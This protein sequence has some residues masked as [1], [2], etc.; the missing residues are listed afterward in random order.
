M[1]RCT[2]FFVGLALHLAF[3]ITLCRTHLGGEEFRDLITVQR[4]GWGF[5]LYSEIDWMYGP[6]Y[7]YLLQ[8]VFSL[9]GAAYEILNVRL[10]AVGFATIGYGAAYASCRGLMG[11]WW[12]VLAALLAGRAFLPPRATYNHHLAVAAFLAAAALL[13]SYAKRPRPGKVLAL[14][15]VAAV[16]L[17]SKPLPLGVG[18]FAGAAALIAC[19][20]WRRGGEIGWGH[21]AVFAV[22]ATG[23]TTVVY[24]TIGSQAGWDVMVGRLYPYPVY[25]ERMTF[26]PLGPL[27]N[28]GSAL[29][30]LKAAVLR[31]GLPDDRFS[32][33]LEALLVG[34]DM[35]ALVAGTIL[36]AGGLSAGRERGRTDTMLI[37][38]GAAILADVEFLFAGRQMATTVA[39]APTALLLVVVI[40]SM[41]RGARRW[42]SGRIGSWGRWV[43]G[44]ILLG[45]IC[46]ALLRLVP[47]SAS[48]LFPARDHPVR[49]AY[50]AVL[51]IPG[52]R[53][54]RLSS[55]SK[56]EIEAA[57]K[58]L[59]RTID[60]SQTVG[61]F[62]SDFIA[63]FHAA[64][65]NVF[66][67][68]IQLFSHGPGI[69]I[70]R[71]GWRPSTP[72]AEIRRIVEDQT[73]DR[74]IV[75]LDAIREKGWRRTCWALE[76]FQ[77]Q[78]LPYVPAP[79]DAGFSCGKNAK[80]FVVAE[81]TGGGDG[82]DPGVS[83][84]RGR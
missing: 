78:R 70:F 69:R 19:L 41:F 6:L 83:S 2:P 21:V 30:T 1:K 4:L 68:D 57:F 14:A 51:E 55:A 22:V 47:F 76:E 75:V 67:G 64:G 12:S 44:G 84:N 28:L 11:P 72:E 74:I 18:L 38:L 81:R 39:R 36:V 54:I 37:L 25:T 56:T 10:V 17:L 16:G 50:D 3:H 46:P 45:A 29:L 73:P 48:A 8:W 71:A 9:T 43:G 42:G 13:A 32:D 60:S 34:L 7:P 58:R 35:T 24:A 82:G 49:G 80:A 66:A 31:G 52:A 5:G 79:E 65:K 23:I 15:A 59:L 40:E 33:V 27:E 63:A 62:G 26:H 20:T 77:R 61:V 53:G